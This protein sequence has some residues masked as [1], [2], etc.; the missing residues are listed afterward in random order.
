MVHGLR[1]ASKDGYMTDFRSSG[2]PATAPGSQHSHMSQFPQDELVGSEEEAKKFV[3]KRVAEGA[4][5]IKIIAD[6]PGF[7]QNTINALVVR[8]QV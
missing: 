5:Y 7:R 8:I 1:A 4:D 3:E 2:F 6:L